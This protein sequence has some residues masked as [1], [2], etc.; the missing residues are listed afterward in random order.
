[1][2]SHYRPAFNVAVYGAAE[3]RRIGIGKTDCEVTTTTDK[4]KRFCEE[5]LVDL[6]AT[7]AA[8]RAGYSPKSAHVIATENMQ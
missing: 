7:Q 1:M 2:K 6:N 5:Y 8:I 4:Q 3:A